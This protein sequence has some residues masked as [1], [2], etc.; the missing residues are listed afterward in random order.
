MKV[1]ADGDILH[2]GRLDGWRGGTGGTRQRDNYLDRGESDRRG[3]G[4]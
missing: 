3:R 4:R 1:K 2:R